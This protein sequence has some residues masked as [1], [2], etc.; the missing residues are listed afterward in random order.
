MAKASAVR[1]TFRLKSLRERLNN[2]RGG[3]RETELNELTVTPW[4]VPSSPRAVTTATPVGNMPSVFR[5]IRSV[6]VIFPSFALLS[7]AASLWRDSLT[8]REHDLH[9]R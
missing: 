8:A 2:T 4:G 7:F 3:S 9:I 5:N 6:K 1:K